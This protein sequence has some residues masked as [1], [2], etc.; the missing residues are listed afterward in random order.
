MHNVVFYSLRIQLSDD[1]RKEQEELEQIAA[2][3]P[4]YLESLQD[5][6][7]TLKEKQDVDRSKTVKKA[8]QQLWR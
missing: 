6:L 1:Y 3:Q 8:Y 2:K 5:R 4:T 7:K